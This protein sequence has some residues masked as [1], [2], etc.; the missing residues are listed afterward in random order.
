MF[1]CMLCCGTVD[2]ECP[3]YSIK[4]WAWIMLWS[5]QMVASSWRRIPMCEQKRTTQTQ[6][7]FLVGFV[8]TISISCQNRSANCLKFW[9]DKIATKSTPQN[10]ENLS[11]LNSSKWPKD[12]NHEKNWKNVFAKNSASVVLQSFFKLPT[13][14]KNTKN[15]QLMTKKP[16]N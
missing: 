9:M 7:W 11:T 1:Y 16:K 10:D 2:T 14:Q 8:A 15:E 6:V 5:L 3:W 4:S 13:S 12:K